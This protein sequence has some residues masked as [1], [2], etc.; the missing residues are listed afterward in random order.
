VGSTLTYAE[1]R[2]GLRIGYDVLAHGFA[3]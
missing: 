3:R 2:I 1:N